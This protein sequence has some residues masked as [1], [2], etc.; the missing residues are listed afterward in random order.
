MRSRSVPAIVAVLTAGALLACSNPGGEGAMESGGEGQ[1][2]SSAGGSGSAEAAVSTLTEQYES[3][4]GYLLSAAEQVPE[5]QYSFRPT[6]EVQD[7][8]GILGH[9]AQ[10]Q[11]AYC[12][13]AN[14]E[15][16]PSAAGEEVTA[17]SAIVEKLRASRDYCLQI[18]RQTSAGA[19]GESADVFGNESTRVGA[20]VSNLAHDNLH[21]GNIVTYMRSI[22]M[23][24]PSSQ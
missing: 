8:G 16:M 24:P 17:K 21:Y 15:E 2:S 22:D 6:E 1:M 13:A 18:Y 9:V 7:L 5:D 14:G 10:A 11:Y 4:S 19:L 20:L 23:V 12:S 3:V